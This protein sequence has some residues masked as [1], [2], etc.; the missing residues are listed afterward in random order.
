LPLNTGQI[1][2]ERY[3]IEQLLGKGGYGAVYIAWDSTF[4]VP[5]AVKENSETTPEAQRQFVREARLLHT[6]RHPNLPL[7]KDYFV[8]EGHGQYLVMDYVEGEDLQQKLDLS[9]G[10]LPEAQVLTWVSQVCQ[11]LEYLH[12]QIPAVI[13]RD[14]KP[15][16][17]K[18]TPQG[19]AVLVDFGIAKQSDPTRPTTKGAQAATPG[20]APFEQYG[21]APT[22]ARSDLYSLGATL[23]H[24]LTAK[25]PVES[26]SRMRGVTLDNPRTLNPQVSPRSEAALLHAMS[27]Q[28][29][30][31][32]QSAARDAS[33]RRHGRP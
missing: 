18:I 5:C 17:I 16:N 14:I 8:V 20:Y 31:R 4:E 30:G 28:P 19:K 26:I 22:D 1:L 7:V 15:A 29:E 32:C 10:P 21:Q 6:L 27:L 3:R 12:A 2:R 33:R 9:G 25:I 24:L 23:Y 13:H 11:A